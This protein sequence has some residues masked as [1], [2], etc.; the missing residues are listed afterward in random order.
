MFPSLSTS[1]SASISS[2]KPS[3]TSCRRI[4]SRVF[5]RSIRCATAASRPLLFPCCAEEEEPFPIDEPT[6]ED[7]DACVAASSIVTGEAAAARLLARRLLL[8]VVAG[9]EAA[10]VAAAGAGAAFAMMAATEVSGVGSWAGAGTR[11]GPQVWDGYWSQS[12][13]SVMRLA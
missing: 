3:F 4:F 7:E 12:K 10:R 2:W 5:L 13:T 6:E 11:T 8:L 1:S 9:E